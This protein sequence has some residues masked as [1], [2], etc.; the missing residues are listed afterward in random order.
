M[1]SHQTADALYSDEPLRKRRG[2]ERTHARIGA[3]GKDSQA[4]AGCFDISLFAR[5]AQK[6]PPIRWLC[7]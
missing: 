4:A 7:R 2:I 1:T 6:N 3:I 5:P